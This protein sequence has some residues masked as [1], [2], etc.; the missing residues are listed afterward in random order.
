MGKDNTMNI[1]VDTVYWSVIIS[2][3]SY[4]CCVCMQKKVRCFLLNPLLISTILTIVFLC[5]FKIDYD[6]YCK[7]AEIFYYLLTPA[8]VCLSVPLYEQIVVLKKN[9]KAILCGITSG[10][11]ASLISILAFSVIFSFSHTMY[12]TL[13]PKSVTTAIAMSVSEENGGISSLTVPIVIMTGITGHIVAEKVLKIFRISDPIAKGV[14]I[15]SSSHAMGTVKA[16]EIGEVEGAMSSLSI[17]VSG[18]ITV[19]GVSLFVELY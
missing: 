6:Q 19:I 17:A 12:V 14:A 11:F 8:T 18:L 5:L 7:K 13:L 15:G 3:G 4:V 16:I 1:F 9:I 10:V 2:V